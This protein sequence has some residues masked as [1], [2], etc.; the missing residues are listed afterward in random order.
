MCRDKKWQKR[1]VKNIN[2]EELSVQEVPENFTHSPN[3]SGKPEI[4]Y[5]KNIPHIIYQSNQACR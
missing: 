1:V 3:F 2:S 5:K 4:T